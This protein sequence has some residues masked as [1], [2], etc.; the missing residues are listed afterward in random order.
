MAT[1]NILVVTGPK[2]E[3]NRFIE[4]ARTQE[5]ALSL[6]ALLPVPDIV[7]ADEANWC[8]KH[9]GDSSDAELYATISEQNEADDRA[10]Q[11]RGHLDLDAQLEIDEVLSTRFDESAIRRHGTFSI[12]PAAT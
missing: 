7:C 2:T 4:G 10:R 1:K 8:L 6:Q 11:K 3:L 12:P 5:H 9:W